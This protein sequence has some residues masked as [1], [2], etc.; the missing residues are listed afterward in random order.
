MGADEAEDGGEFEEGEL[1]VG[2]AGEVGCA[3]CFEVVGVDEGGGGAF[4]DDAGV[5]VQRIPVVRGRGRR[6]VHREGD[7]GVCRAAPLLCEH[8]LDKDGFFGMVLGGGE[9]HAEKHVVVLFVDRGG[10]PAVVSGG[11]GMRDA[12]LDPVYESVV[13]VDQLARPGVERRRT[14]EDGRLQVTMV[15]DLGEI[16]RQGVLEQMHGRDSESELGGGSRSWS[17]VK[18]CEE[19]AGSKNLSVSG[20]SPYGPGAHDPTPPHGSGGRGLDCG[21]SGV[22]TKLFIRQPHTLRKGKAE[23]KRLYRVYVREKAMG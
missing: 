15:H 23:K 9:R 10:T 16:V 8:A 18:P 14:I 12:C 21:M 1:A 7:D 13:L 6:G 20:K 22:R 5:V 2:A 11:H 19:P 4:E 17:E 3:V